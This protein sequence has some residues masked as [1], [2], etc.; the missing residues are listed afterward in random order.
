MASTKVESIFSDADS[1]VTGISSPDIDFID[2]KLK[3]ANITMEE[4]AIQFTVRGNAQPSMPV[5]AKVCTVC[6]EEADLT[7]AG[8]KN[9]PDHENTSYCSPECQKADW[10]NHMPQCKFSKAKK[11]LFRAGD[12]MQELW[13]GPLV[14]DNTQCTDSISRYAHREMSFDKNFAKLENKGNVIYLQEGSG[15]KKPFY[16]FP[17]EICETEIE[18]HAVLSF[19]GSME[20]VAAF[21]PFVVRLLKSTH[22]KF[23]SPIQF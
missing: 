11:G 7:C 20:A 3:S 18:K 2:E 8:C 4:A 15:E 22:P 21:Q 14:H 1:S 10:K 23:I 19:L 5:L 16:K 13:Y 17:N 9:T 12:L 6:Q